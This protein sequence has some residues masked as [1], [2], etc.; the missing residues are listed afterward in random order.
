MID[1]TPPSQISKKNTML[2]QTCEICHDQY[3]VP[4]HIAFRYT[5]CS[6]ACSSKKKRTLRTV[7]PEFA[8]EICGETFTVRECIARIGKVKYCSNECRLVG[9]N[10]QERVRTPGLMNIVTTARGY[11]RGHAWIDGE[12]KLVLE[13]RWV[14]EQHLGRRLAPQE[15]VH[16][17]NEDRC[18]NRIVNLHLYS[19]HA[20]HL[21][22]EHMNN[23]RLLAIHNHERQQSPLT[24]QDDPSDR[25]R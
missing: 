11:R 25:Q 16:H 10:Q 18:D 8:C 22:H 3:Q 17:I 14:M 21:R 24:Q 2:I 13:H 6:Q 9:L 4:K 12:L 1:R 15:R 5:T 7:R 20:E 23:I 19:S